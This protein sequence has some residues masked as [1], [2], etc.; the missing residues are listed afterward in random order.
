[1]RIDPRDRDVDR[2]GRDRGQPRRAGR[3]RRDRVDRRACAHRL[4][5]RRHPAREPPRCPMPADAVPDRAGLLLPADVALPRRPGR[6]PASRRLGGRDARGQ[7][8]H[9][10]AGAER[11]RA[12]VRVQAAPERPLLQRSPRQARGRPRVDRA[13]DDAAAE[14][15]FLPDVPADSGSGTLQRAGAAISRA[16]IETDSAARTVTIHLRRPDPDFL[17]K[18]ESIYR[19][20]GRDPGAGGENASGAGH[21]PV[22]GRALGPGARRRAGPQPALRRVVARPA[23]RLPG[24]DRH[25]A[26]EAASAGRRGGARRR[27]H[28]PAPS[29]DPRRH[30]APDAVWRTAAHR[31]QRR[32]VV[33][34]PQ[35][36]HPAVRRPSRPAGAQLR[37]RSRPRRQALRQPRDTRADVPAAAA[38]APGIRADV[39]LHGEPEPAR[40]PGSAPTWPGHAASSPRP[41]RA[42]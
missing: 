27:G 18:L 9:R 39:S 8:G 31:P 7:P 20:A 14:R 29:R 16:G 28:R 42:A 10:G 34:V 21:G 15:R 12:D 38:G 33:R 19:R 30:R 6:L 36:P 40:A 24:R 35:R 22:H 5:P 37:G 4:A 32:H 23:R 2:H 17:H 1:M 41:G 11:G 3:G 13:P 25:P 26:R